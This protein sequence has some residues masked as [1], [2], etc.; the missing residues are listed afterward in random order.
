MSR[1]KGESREKKTFFL[2]YFLAIKSSKAYDE[3]IGMKGKGA[4][5][6]KLEVK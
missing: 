4:R 1:G 3:D 5:K 6:D 2:L